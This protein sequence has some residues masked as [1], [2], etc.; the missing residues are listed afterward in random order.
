[1]E[2]DMNTPDAFSM[3]FPQMPTPDWMSKFADPAAW[4]SWMKVPDGG[5]GAAAM[6][7]V[8]R[9]LGD[10]G[11]MLPPDRM[12]A[13]R[14]DYLQKASQLWQDFASGKTPEFK[15]KRFSAPE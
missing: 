6:A 3:P 12:E 15:D 11:T 4:Q 13:L 14:N 8:M 7:P 9:M 2:A 5:D 10:A 1:M